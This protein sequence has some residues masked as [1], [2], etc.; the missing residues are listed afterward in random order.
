MHEEMSS[1]IEY[2][3]NKRDVKA[4]R[5]TY[6]KSLKRVSSLARNDKQ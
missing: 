1:E 5:K 3:G 2:Q 6:E 4:A